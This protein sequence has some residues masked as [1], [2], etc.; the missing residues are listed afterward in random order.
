MI[1]SASS[2]WLKRNQ[3]WLLN[4]ANTDF[5]RD[6]LQLP[7]N[8]IKIAPNRVV[9]LLGN[10]N[11]KATVASDY[12]THDKWAK[13]IRTRFG[14]IQSY[15]KYFEYKS[16]DISP[17]AKAALSM[18]ATTD[19]YFP[20]PGTLVD[21]YLY[22]GSRATW[23]LA[24]DLAS[25]ASVNFNATN[26]QVA[27]ST[28]VNGSSW[29]ILRSAYVFNTAS[30]PDT[31]AISSAT[32]SLFGDGGSPTNADSTSLELVSCTL[33]ANHF[34]TEDDYNN[35]GAVSMGTIALASWN[36]AAYN[37]L[38]LNASGISNISLSGNSYFG[39][40]TGLDLN[41]TT[42]TGSNLATAYYSDQ[43]GT[44]NDPKLVV[45]HDVPAAFIPRL[46]VI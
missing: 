8:V 9:S 31:N 25:A 40:R 6:L 43:G 3:G 13:L 16:K 34:L 29:V 12:R 35:L 20:A 22:S 36:T 5:G 14:E 24:R 44:T 7:K 46:I 30:I 37:N 2:L 33:T 32:F 23:T 27:E 41:N 11:G 4:M 21:G 17:L 42:P 26:E 39:I 10:E 45:V 28:R 15:A 38:A 19:T 18:V 1:E